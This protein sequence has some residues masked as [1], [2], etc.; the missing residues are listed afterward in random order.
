[1]PD[2]R[3]GLAL[4]LELHGF[5]HSFI[6]VITTNNRFDKVNAISHYLRDFKIEL[7]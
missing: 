4:H 1:M 7:H 3:P 6:F 2:A 5:S